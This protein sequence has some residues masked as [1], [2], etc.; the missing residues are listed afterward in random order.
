MKLIQ[1]S[2]LFFKEGNSDKVYEI[3]LCELSS[4]EYLVNFRFGRRGSAL[5]EGTKT[6]ATVSKEKAEQIFGALES[7]KTRKGYQTE[8]ATF[9]ELPLLTDIKTDTDKGVILKR[10]QDA[11]EK[12]NSFRTEWKTSRVIWKAGCLKIKEAAPFIIRLATK[13]DDFQIYSSLW[14]LIQL[15]APEAEELFKSFAFQVK[16]KSYIRNIAFEGLMDI[17]DKEQQTT[18]SGALLEKMPSELATCLMNKDYCGIKAE[19]ADCSKKKNVAFFPNLYLLCKIH[20]EL[21]NC[22]IESIKEWEFKP[23]YFKQ[24]RS[25][26]KLAQI[27]KDYTTLAYLSYRFEKEEPMFRRTDALDS[28]RKQYMDAIDERVCVGSELKKEDS[29]LAFSQYTK[30]YFRKNSA[31]FLRKS[32]TN[33]EAKDYL[34]LAV[35]ILLE[36]DSS[37]HSKAEERPQSEYGTYDRKKKKYFYTLFNYPECSE[38]FLLNTILFGNDPDRILM[39][40]L[41]YV[42]G[43]RTVYCSRYYFTPDSFEDVSGNNV[44]TGQ[45]GSVVTSVM[46]G[47]KNLFGKR[48]PAKGVEE[49]PQTAPDNEPREKCVNTELFPEHWN[50]LP[51][52][53]I[54]LLMQARLD[55]IHTFAYKKIT[56][57]PDYEKICDRFDEKGI[58]QLLR[59][60]YSIPNKF[61]FDLLMKKKELFSKDPLLIAE[62]LNSYNADAVNWAKE[63]VNN[64]TSFYLSNLEFVL[65]LICNSV[66]DND[67][68]ICELLQKARFDE[69]RIQSLLGKLVAH[70]IQLDNTDENNNI[71][72]YIISRINI[73]AF[74]Y[75]DLISWN[76]IEQL[77][78]SPLMTNSLLAGNILVK[79]SKKTDPTQIPVSLVGLFLQ[80]ELPAIRENGIE[81]F[82]A[83]PDN[84]LIQH[85]DFVTNLLNSSYN[86]VMD[87]AIKS[88][89]KMLRYDS[90]LGKKMLYPAM[91]VLIRKEKF[92]GAHAIVSELINSDLKNSRGELIPKQITGLIH[93]HYR[94]GQLTGLNMLQEYNNHN[95]FSIG[96]IISF[97]N[98]EL[99]EIRQWCRNYFSGNVARIRFEKEKSL[100]ILDSNWDDTRTFAFQFFKKEFTASDWDTDTLIAITDSIRPDVEQFGKELIMMYFDKSAALEF[101]TKLSEHPSLNVQ[102]FV[103]N[104]LSA[105]ASDR[106]ELIESLEYY[107]RSVL[108]R[109]NKA[110][111]AK[112]H[113]FSFLHNE[114]VKNEKTARFVIPVLDDISALSPVQDKETCIHI[115][116]ELN[117][118]YP[119]LDMHLEIKY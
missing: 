4:D 40:N 47:L 11:I 3:D 103:S 10:L 90:S 79:K 73:F 43:K 100:N 5:K 58:T 85:I 116:T 65:S 88:I 16:Q 92:E 97:G 19:L 28:K 64:N 84:F 33:D 113:V 7:E 63:T 114:A 104:Y 31:S 8:V 106:P 27:R 9:I 36:Y 70:L 45:G 119:H 34:R 99:M 95:D 12:K 18:L 75:L 80:N 108:T 57:H 109:V 66:K 14:A 29:K 32:G 117:K 69:S 41:S 83:Y 49:K 53:S 115:L 81:L 68:W 50:A 42:S 37:D 98:H 93:S 38:S 2:R 101:L 102:A 62:V 51:E 6:P 23:P 55:I 22:L 87:A 112:N 77:L 111:V 1:Q 25:I 26:Y 76:V 60:N 105:Y 35:S 72:I 56:N 110:R 86:D 17:P 82:L 89:R 20:P 54:Q 94:V 21:L 61:G 52:A 46:S 107:F 78:I 71:A 48:E 15:K 39:R 24:I 96:Q 91:L 30:H 59:R 74:N 13:G 44:E 118:L 67:A